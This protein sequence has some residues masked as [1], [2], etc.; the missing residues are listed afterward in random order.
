MKRQHIYYFDYLRIL[1]MTAVVFM[2][3]AADPLRMGVNTQW[4]FLNILTSLSF[5][6][7]PLFFMMSGYL[8]LSGDMNTAYIPK[9]VRHRIPRLL[10]PLAGWTVVAVLW[11]VLLSKNWTLG[12]VWD[13]LVY[14]LHDPVMIHFWYMYTLIA[15]Y[16]IS[17]VFSGVKRLDTKGKAFIF[18]LIALC[19]LY[20]AVNAVLTLFSAGS[21]SIDLFAK[22]LGWGAGGHLL[23]FFLGYILGST[24]IR[25]PNL[26]LIL[27]SA[28]VLAV[29]TVSTYILTVRGGEYNQLFQGQSSGFE[30]ILAALIFLLFKQNL[31]KKPKFFGGLVRC[32]VSL[33]LPVYMMHNILISML[34]SVGAAPKGFFGTVAYTAVVI[35]ICVIVLKTVA[36][37][38]PICYIA[39]G[40]TWDEASKSCNWIYTYRNIKNRNVQE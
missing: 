14:S 2:H 8:V 4:Q 6:A 26:I 31:N 13:K 37:V 23:T 24:K 35:V 18:S 36:T 10:I 38:K 3:T 25:V 30:V 32:L 1:A 28:A 20:T 34:Y 11:Q 19:S 17:P 29:I 33:S 21:I 16:V 40:M 9:L 22:L 12:A 15:I 27:S 39:T 5:C 7:V